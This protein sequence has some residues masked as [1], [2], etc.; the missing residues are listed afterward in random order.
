MYHELTRVLQSI[1]KPYIL[2]GDYNEII[3]IGD[4]RGQTT[5]TASMKQFHKFITNNHLLVI[6]LIGKKFTW[7]RGNS[8]GR[9][10]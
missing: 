9:I 10:D 2:M 6:N 5:V 4:R 3:G 1:E 7:G 8:R